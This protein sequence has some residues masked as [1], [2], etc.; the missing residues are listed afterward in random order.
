ML[1]AKVILSYTCGHLPATA[2]SSE[3]HLKASP[4]LTSLSINEE[5][6]DELVCELKLEWI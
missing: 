5:A 2:D 3:I 6:C 4:T 1:K